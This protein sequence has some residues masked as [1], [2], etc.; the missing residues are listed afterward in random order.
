MRRRRQSIALAIVVAAL[1]ACAVAAAPAGAAAPT[2]VEVSGIITL[3][4]NV[5]LSTQTL[6]V[7]SRTESIAEVSFSGDMIGW[8]TEPYSTLF[9][10]SGTILQWGTGSF[11]GEVDGRSGTISYVFHGDAAA[12]GVITITGGT[13]DLTGAHGRIAYTPAPGTPPQFTYE[14]T[15]TLP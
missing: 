10:S 1:A 15:V 12:G 6:G 2:K 11:T 13:G 8:A 3:D 9:L 14:G 5:D 4:S 7:N